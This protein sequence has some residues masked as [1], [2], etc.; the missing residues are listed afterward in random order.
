[1]PGTIAQ[2]TSGRSNSRRV[3]VTS[4][5]SLAVAADREDDVLALGAADAADGLVDRLALG[6]LAVDGDLIRSPRW[7]PASSAGVFGNTVEIEIAPSSP[8]LTW[9]PMPTNEPDSDWS[10][11]CASS[12]VMN[13]VCPS[14][15]TAS[16]MRPDRR[17]G[18]LLVVEAVGVDVVVVDGA[19]GLVD[20]GRCRRARRWAAGV[21]VPAWSGPPPSAPPVPP[22]GDAGREH[23][24]R[25]HGREHQHQRAGDP[26]A[27]E[28]AAALDRHG[29]RGRRAAAAG[30]TGV[31]PGAADQA[32]P[33]ARSG[34]WG[35]APGRRGGRVVGPGWASVR[36]CVSFVQGSAE[37][38]SARASMTY[39]ASARVDVG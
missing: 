12:A 15:P 4:K 31:A 6:G 9:T 2:L 8:S 22:D 11:A 27:A 32:G 1:M 26:A 20:E 38:W 18:Q 34:R 7:R 25:E 19:P 16:V 21:A 30:V 3:I 33:P 36:S 37:A 5:S 35:G 10:A 28:A 13:E 17:V 29:G 24:D 14:S 39:V 23:D